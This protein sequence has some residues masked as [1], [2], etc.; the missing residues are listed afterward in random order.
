M[1]QKERTLCSVDR[2]RDIV[3]KGRMCADTRSATDLMVWQVGCFSDRY[4]HWWE[5]AR[6][7][8]QTTRLM[9]SREE[10][11]RWRGAFWPRGYG[12]SRSA[13]KKVLAKGGNE[14]EKA[15]CPRRVRT[16]SRRGPT[17]GAVSC[18][19]PRS[20]VLGGRHGSDSAQGV[21]RELPP[22]AEAP[23]NSK[24]TGDVSCTGRV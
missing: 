19:A 4:G 2:T 6:N 1:K 12:L 14:K 22:G 20:W 9:H 5:I 10:S 13:A 24:A 18:P 11:W 16:A 17:S 8:G 15:C 23:S 7:R 3:L 21:A